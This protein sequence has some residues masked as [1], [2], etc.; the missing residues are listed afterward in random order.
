M[1]L[2]RRVLAH[3]LANAIAL[4]FVSVI[5]DGKFVITG[6]WKGYLIAALIFGLLNAIVKPILKV[7]SLPFVVISAGLFLFIINMFLVWFAKYT[8]D[9]LKFEGVAITIT[10]ISTYLIA[11]F[12]IALLNMIIGWLLKK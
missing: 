2:L 5:L 4:Y 11:G 12:L 1:N 8:L 6:E 3:I 10:G 7:L 9:V